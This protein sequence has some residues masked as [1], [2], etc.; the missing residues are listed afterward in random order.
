MTAPTL[1]ASASPAVDRAP[2]YAAEIVSAYVGNNSVAAAD[3]PDLIR[4]VHTALTQLDQPE[5][6]GG[7]TPEQRRQP[8]VPIRRSITPDYLI[9][10]EDGRQYRSLKRHLKGRGLT[11]TEY[12]SKWGL[13]PDYPMVAPNY[14]ARRS[15]LARS[16]GFGRKRQAEAA[17]GSAALVHEEPSGPGTRRSTKKRPI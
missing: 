9:S 14:S 10:L 15:E 5:P 16:L 12:R 13:P 17:P 11:P 2:G 3:L 7:T 4:S 6:A 8:A 1:D